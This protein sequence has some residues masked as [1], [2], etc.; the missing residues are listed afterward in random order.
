MNTM[1]Q[2]CLQQLESCNRLSIGV[3]LM[4]VGT[5]LAP[6]LTSSAHLSIVGSIPAPST[7]DQE[8]SLVSNADDP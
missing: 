2:L 4:P 8:Y 1:E 7:L 6:V 3:T 5:I